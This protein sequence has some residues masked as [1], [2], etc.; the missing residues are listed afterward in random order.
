MDYLWFEVGMEVIRNSL[1]KVKTILD[2][3][4]PQ[5]MHD[6]RLFLG[7][8]SHYSKVCQRILAVG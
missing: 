7:S 5:S 3:R 6:V 1:D 8:D 2:W 4:T